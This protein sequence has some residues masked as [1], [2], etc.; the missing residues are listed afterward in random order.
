MPSR[1]DVDR[2]LALHRLAFVGVSRDPKQF[3]N[4]V[5][6]KFRDDG[7][8]MYPVNAGAA[9]APLEGDPSYE[10]LAAVPDDVEGV[11]VMVP[12]AKAAGV[13][14]DA[15]ARGIRNVWLYKG[16]GPGSTSD[17]AVAQCRA[18]GALVVDGAC[19]FMFGDDVRGFHRVH[20]FFARHRFAA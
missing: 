17:D 1:A 2:F 12:E 18:A 7:R 6:R 11:V 13:V 20:R 16:I 15:L 4:S 14:D 3:S 8:T 19:P 10:T 5:Y 9:G